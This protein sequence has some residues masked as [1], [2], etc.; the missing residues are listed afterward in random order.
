MS[1]LDPK[2]EKELRELPELAP[3]PAF[4]RRVLAVAAA[5]RQER[6]S[7]WR[8]LLRSGENRALASGF[9]CAVAV[10]VALLAL[11]MPSVATRGTTTASSS[12]NLLYPSEPM[13]VAFA[14]ETR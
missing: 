9:L 3:D 7:Q 14:E 4:R 10:S 11:V 8:M 13:V 2:L 5:T 1:D 12:T 6:P